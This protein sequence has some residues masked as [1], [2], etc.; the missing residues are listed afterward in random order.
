MSLDIASRI[1]VSSLMTTQVQM[2]VASANIS[3]ADTNGYTVKTAN[4]ESVVSV[5]SGAG[6]TISGITSNVDKLLLKSLSAANSDL[7]AAD[8]S[9]SYLDQLQNLYGSSGSSSSSG[10]SIAN[11][12]ASLESAISSLS[13]TTN[14]AALQSNVV[15]TLDSVASQLRETSSGIQNLRG[16]ADKDIASSIDDVNQQLKSI[17]DLNAEIKQTKAAGQSTADLEDKRNT[18]M[19]DVASKMNVSYFVSS[20]GDMQVYTTSGQVL[21]DSSAHKLSYTAASSVTAS[22]TYSAT[23]SSG[24]SGITVNG[25]DVTSQITSGKIGGLINL[26]DTV[27][28]GAQTQLDQLANQLSDSLNTVHNQGASIPPPH[29][30]TGT[31]TVS[32]STALS[33]SGTVRIAVADQKGSLVSYKDLD[34][35]TYST[36]GDLVSGI[37]SISGL[38]SSIDTNGHVVIAS[39]SSSNGVAINEMSSKVG[40][41]GA[42]L[43][44]AL[45]LNDLVTGT[46][47]SNFAVRSD[48]LSNS[49]RLAVS[50]LDS[51][52]SLTTGRSVLSSGSTTVVDNLHSALTASNSY[53]AA[54]GLGATSGSAS[55]YASAIVSSAASKAS[56]AKN[57]Y[58][59]KET[60]QS[61]F[62]SAMSSQSGV[63]L[64]E[65]TAR[66][67]TLQNQYS[68]VSEL[69]K[70]INSMFSDLLDAVKSSH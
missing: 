17:S 34:L 55:D 27:L 37:N 2:S 18:A 5:G 3:N 66:L 45:G 10:T 9:N 46:G 59:S 13:S 47:A 65:E 67:S 68:A 57:T 15:G 54:G 36:V 30:L 39:T 63:N 61:T 41:S 7:G 14:S 64:D 25:V 26:R 20:S 19:L 29:T 48:I 22:T 70:T 62:S 8:I 21:V 6:T 32:S 49:G 58:T 35:S 11:S 31:A 16:N 24:L 4:Q 38:S 43:S 56:D 51:S 12:I 28:T 40:S 50:T 1:A 44:D 23:S 52:T 53:G 33:A 42:G 69:I 60:A